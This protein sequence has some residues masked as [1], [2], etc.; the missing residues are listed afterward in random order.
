MEGG[1]QLK[2]A[3]LGFAVIFDANA[4]APGLFDLAGEG[5]DL[6]D[7]GKIVV[8]ERIQ[9]AQDLLAVAEG[10]ANVFGIHPQGYKHQRDRYQAEK[11]QLP[12]QEE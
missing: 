2:G 4:N 6:A 7:A 12:I 11:G 9:V 5:L 8:Q 1:H 3:Q 10:R